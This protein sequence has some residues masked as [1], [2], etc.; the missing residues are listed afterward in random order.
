MMKI[1]TIDL[2]FLGLEH[3]IAVFVAEGPDGLA[4]VECG[5]YSTQQHLDEALLERGIP[6]AEIRDVFLSHIHFDHA[7]AAW[8]WAERGAKI[9][10]H[11]KGQP[12]LAAPERLYHSARQIYGNDMD[13]LWGEMRPIAADRLHAPEDGARIMAAGLPFTAHYTPG[14][15]S[16]HI[17]WQLGEGKESVVFTGDVG[18]VKIG[19]GLVQPPCP[20]PD[21]DV[22]AWL[23]SIDLLR[24]LPATDLYLTHFGKISDK[25]THLDALEG[26]LLKWAEWMKPY[27]TM[28]SPPEDLVPLFQAF[29]AAELSDAGVGN[30]DLQRYEAANPAFMSVA[31]LMRYWKKNLAV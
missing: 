24:K 25:S 4:L 8:A 16:H 23:A 15:A 14:H 11:P 12:H 3:A 29:V 31:G 22:E 6:A 27:S 1:H 20:P 10:V 7:G 18:G 13:R 19:D 5:P 26:R 30:A 28:P 21:I 17:A 9:Y 2:E